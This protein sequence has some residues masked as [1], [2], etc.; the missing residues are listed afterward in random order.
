MEQF[1]IPFILTVVLIVLWVLIVRK[2]PE[3][4]SRGITKHI[5]HSYDTKLERIKSEM[6]SNISA[7]QSSVALL[8]ASQSEY[9]NKVISSV[10]GLWLSI[11]ACQEVYSNVVFLHNILTPNEIAINIKRQN[12]PTINH[13]FDE[14]KD[15]SFVMEKQKKIDQNLT[16]TEILYASDKLWSLYQTILQVHG[17]AAVLIQHS[18]SENEYQD[19]RQDELMLSAVK[20]MIPEEQLSSTRNRPM[21]GL[22]DLLNWI[23][24]EFIKEGSSLLQRPMELEK[25]VPEIYSLLKKAAKRNTDR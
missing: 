8:T 9:R 14:Y 15:I 13:I 20:D 7:M 19:W 23:V 4:L 17:R 1:L 18:L 11:K 16:G 2:F 12:N 3:I 5:E 21:G 10:D 22:N 6:Q 24:A 25:S